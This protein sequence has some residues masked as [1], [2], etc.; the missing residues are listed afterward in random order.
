MHCI[1]NLF[2]LLLPIGTNNKLRVTGVTG[3]PLPSTRKVSTTI[4]ELATEKD[5]S[6]K[7]TNMH[8]LWGQFIDHDLGHTPLVPKVTLRFQLLLCKNTL[9]IG[10]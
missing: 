6:V 9:F 5:L 2:Q 7:L 8:M 1:A 4:H 3:K 10:I